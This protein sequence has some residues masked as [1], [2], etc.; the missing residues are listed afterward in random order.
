MGTTGT[1]VDRATEV[2]ANK[3]RH[4]LFMT[5][6]GLVAFAFGAYLKGALASGRAHEQH[7]FFL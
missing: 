4:W 5:A 1:F 2:M 7:Q 6:A 3:N